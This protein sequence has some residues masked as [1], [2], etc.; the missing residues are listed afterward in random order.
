MQLDVERPWLTCTKCPL[1]KTRTK[2]VIGYGNPSTKFV[3]VGEGPGMTED[4]I[5]KPF[6]GDSGDILNAFLDAAGLPREFVF[7]DN[8]VACMPFNAEGKRKVIRP[9][10]PA[11]LAACKPRLMAALQAIDPVLILAIGGTAFRVL[12]DC[13]DPIS[14]ARGDVFYAKIPGK[15]MEVLVPLIPI[16]HPAYLMR[17]ENIK[18]RR[19]EGS[20]WEQTAKDI[21]AAVTIFKA[22]VKA[23]YNVDIGG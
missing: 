5:G 2:T 17:S 11:E 1:G 10:N 6:V 23:Y 19:R 8:C 14:K 3:C 22:L 9:P 18:N 7:V 12:T 15:E 13:K 16:Y 4:R 21:A 20:T